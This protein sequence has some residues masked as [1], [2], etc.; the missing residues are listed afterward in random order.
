MTAAEKVVQVVMAHLKIVLVST[1]NSCIF[2]LGLGSLV[3]RL[4]FSFL[5]VIKRLYLYVISSVEIS[6]FTTIKTP[7]QE[8]EEEIVSNRW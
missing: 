4:F 7:Q 2:F 3:T 6:S 5:S 1:V 8:K